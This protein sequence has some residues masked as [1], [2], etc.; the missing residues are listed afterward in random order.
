MQKQPCLTVFGLIWAV[1]QSE[2]ER[3]RERERKLELISADGYISTADGNIP[4]I[5]IYTHTCK[6]ACLYVCM[7]ACMYV[8]MYVYMYVCMNVCM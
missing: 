6:H 4:V 1:L 7:Y 8:C 3:E 2:R 5:Y